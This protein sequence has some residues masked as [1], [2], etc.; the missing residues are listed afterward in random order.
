[1]GLPKRLRGISLSDVYYFEE[2]PDD[3]VSATSGFGLHETFCAPRD[4]L[5][6]IACHM[7]LYI[8]V[9]VNYPPDLIAVF[10]GLQKPPDNPPLSQEVPDDGPILR[11]L[12]LKRFTALHMPLQP[13]RH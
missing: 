6:I 10:M 1:M 4:P 2:F 12:N 13:R 7:K 9:D 11:T 3:R 5:C 8:Y